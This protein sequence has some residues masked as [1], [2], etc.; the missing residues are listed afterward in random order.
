MQWLLVIV[1]PAVHLYV[2][3]YIFTSTFRVLTWPGPCATLCLLQILAL[4]LLK[5]LLDNS[6][7]EFRTGEKFVSAIRQ[8][9]CLSLLKNS[10]SSLPGALQ[11]SGAIFLSLLMRFRAAL[12]VIA[13]PKMGLL[14]E[15]EGLLLA[16]GICSAVWGRSSSAGPCS[17]LYSCGFGLPLR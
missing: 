7:P 15:H 16:P 2:V 5:V 1:T 12:K 11:L 10:A 9:L 17:C 14:I 4:E 6:G 13:G 3:K 8:Y